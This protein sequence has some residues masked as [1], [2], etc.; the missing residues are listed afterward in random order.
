MML[1]VAVDGEVGAEI[2]IQ[3]WRLWLVFLAGRKQHLWC[4]SVRDERFSRSDTS[5][6]DVLCSPTPPLGVRVEVVPEGAEVEVKYI[7]AES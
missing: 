2:V 6:V 1:H 5:C 3:F 7:P 4:D